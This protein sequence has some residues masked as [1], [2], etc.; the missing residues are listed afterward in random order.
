MT[1]TGSNYELLIDNGS[2]TAFLF[3]NG[4]SLLSNLHHTPF[5][6]NN[7]RYR[8]VEQFVWAQKAL[9]F[10]DYLAYQCIMEEWSPRK[11]KDFRIKNF[12]FNRWRNAFEGFL[13]TAL[14]AKFDQNKA[15]Q[16]KLLSTG[17]A[18]LVYATRNDRLL[19]CGL[20]VTDSDVVNEDKWMGSNLLGSMLQLVRSELND[21]D[22]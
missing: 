13:V 10:Q 6:V 3:A 8:N 11:Y 4:Y 2:Y 5:V 12:D 18:H 20:N 14:R 1:S 19:G 9:L 16:Q 21:K 15:A 17:N 22:N 7:V